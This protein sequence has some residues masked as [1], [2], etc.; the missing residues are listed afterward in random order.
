[1][2]LLHA[3][4][5]KERPD[6]EVII[7]RYWPE[8]ELTSMTGDD[9]LKEKLPGY[10][11]FADKERYFLFDEGQTT[12]WDEALWLAFKDT[13]Q[14]MQK[15]V[16]AIL[17]CTYGNEEVRDP[18]SVTPI[19][20]TGA[21]VTLERVHTDGDISFGLLLDKLEFGDVIDRNS[22]L[23]LADDLRDFIY[24]FTRGHVGATLAVAQFL[25]KKVPIYES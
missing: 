15:P 13:I 9:R 7:N 24:D 2:D 20:L 11:S 3:R 22:K 5:L 10:P 1:M 14:S 12:Y 6:A 18:K 21:R 4:I 17:F 23:R 8:K 19:D 16:Y 25:L